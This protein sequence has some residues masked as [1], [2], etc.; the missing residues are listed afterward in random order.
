MLNWRDEYQRKLTTADE[1]AKVVKSGDR[2][3]CTAG[4]EPLAIGQALTARK[5]ELKGVEIFLPTPTF[6]FGW[7]DPGWEDNFTV[8]VGYIFPGGVASRAIEEKRNDFLVGELL[9]WHGLSQ[10]RKVDVLLTELS[11]PDEHGFCSF[12]ASVYDKRSW[13]LKAG[14]VLAEVNNNL[15]RT[16]GDNFVHISQIDY[17]VEHPS[18]GRAPGAVDLSGRPLV[19]LPEYVKTISGY[20]STLIKDGDTLQIGTGGTSESLVRAGLM[21]NKQEL[22]WHS[23][24][25]APGIIRLVREEVVTGKYKTIDQGKAVATAIGGGTKEE[26]DFVFMNPMFELRDVEYTH[27][28]K[29]I[30]RLDNIIAINNTLNIDL[31]GQIAAESLGA[32]M[33]SGGGGLLAFATGAALSRG[34][35]FVIV[36]PSTT[37]NGNI[38]RIVAQLEPGT[39][40][41][42]P[43]TLADIVVTEYGIAKLK[44]KTQRQRA[45][46]L[47]AIAHPDFRVELR[48]ETQ[49]LYYS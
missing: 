16:Y 26:M 28:P 34:G 23:E 17:F 39:I 48:K 6:D 42:V 21:D 4:R 32:R 36:L 27:N 30:S 18:T 41:T 25:T 1:A 9:L 40:I 2:V 24:V 44:G 19:E 35:R 31:T 13:L 46:E 47:I 11:P 8:Q 5:E 33:F 15:I 14:L 7:Y 37:G 29:T 3:V 22:G 20:V 49:G 10:I 38:S 43:R 12:G 45:Q